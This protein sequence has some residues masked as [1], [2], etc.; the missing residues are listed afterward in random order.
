[1]SVTLELVQNGV[2]LNSYQHEGRRYVEAPP[3]GAY[4]IRLRNLSSSSKLCVL[5][6]DGRNIV[7][8]S[9]AN[10]AGPG[11]V[12]APYRTADIKGWRRT[13]SEVAAFEFK[14][15]EQSY[16][17]KMGDGTSN[18]GVVGLAVF[19]EKV[20]SPAASVSLT[21][22]SGWSQDSHPYQ[23]V[24]ESYK[25][26]GSNDDNN[27]NLM[28]DPQYNSDN[29]FHSAGPCDAAPCAADDTDGVDLIS[30]TLG[31]RPKIGIRGLRS[32][33]DLGTGYGSKTSMFTTESTFERATSTP[34]FVFQ[35]QYAMR[36]RLIEWGVPV[37]KP[38]PTP[39]AFPAASIGVRAP[40]GW[41]G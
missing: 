32:A 35:V 30:D 31:S 12:L 17:M 5:S 28:R 20:R 10:F 24:Q 39:N 3:E 16:A 14:P 2:V 26:K 22:R 37:S 25:G 21:P 18:T 27:L 6:V 15:Q 36:E 11:Y 40:A 8:G 19:E 41:T 34:A 23:K 33:V 1:M 9:E 7:D 29:T 4:F 13:A 38:S